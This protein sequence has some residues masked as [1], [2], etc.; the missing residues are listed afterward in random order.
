M[1]D[2]TVGLAG[3]DLD[4]LRRACG[5]VI[6]GDDAAYDEARRLWKEVNRP[7]VMIKVPA[8]PEGIPAIESLLAEGININITLMFP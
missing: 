2:A 5:E 1:V 7:N 3:R 6:T 8:T 4:R